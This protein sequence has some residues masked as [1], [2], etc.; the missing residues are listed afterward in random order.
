MEERLDDAINVLRNH[1]EPQLGIVNPNI[2][3][4]SF[5]G[6]HQVNVPPTSLQH[7]SLE[8]PPVKMERIPNSNSGSNNSK[9]TENLNLKKNKRFIL[10][11]V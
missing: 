2:D 3:N 7:D 4:S 5:I 11:F 6:S 8:N 10:I 9:Y 1:C